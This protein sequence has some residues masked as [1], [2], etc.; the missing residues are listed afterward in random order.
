M[1]AKRKKIFYVPGLL[2]LLVLPFLLI[3]FN[4]LPPPETV[5]RFNLAYDKKPEDERSIVF[6]SMDIKRVIRN[7]KKLTVTFS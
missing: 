7:K 6:T 4:P 5:L 3:Q 1:R 2:S